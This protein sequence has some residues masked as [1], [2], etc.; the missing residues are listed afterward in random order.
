MEGG[1]RCGCDMHLTVCV[2]GC[3]SI[4]LFVSLFIESW[5]QEECAPRADCAP[6]SSNRCV[7]VCVCLKQMCV[8]CKDCVCV[9]VCV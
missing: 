2:Y 3:L 8:R 7:C 4:V 5:Q 9:C 6:G 1:T